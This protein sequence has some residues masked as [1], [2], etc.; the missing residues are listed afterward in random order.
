MMNVALQHR[1]QLWG[2]RQDPSIHDIIGHRHWLTG[3]V[4][5]SYL[6]EYGMEY[7]PILIDFIAS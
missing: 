2:A 3:K 1:E 6:P 4:A 7:M 5:I